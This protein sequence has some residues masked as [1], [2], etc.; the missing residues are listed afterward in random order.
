MIF[1]QARLAE[2][3]GAILAHTHRLPGRT[4]PKGTVLDEAMLAALCAA[5]LDEVVVARPEAGEVAA[6]LV[7][8]RLAALLATPLIARGRAVGGRVELRAEA[9]GLLRVNVTAVERVNAVD[10]AITVA[11]PGDGEMVTS[12]E[13]LAAVTVLPFAV[14]S[15]TVAVVEALARR[16]PLFSLHPFHA[17]RVASV[18]TGP[19]YPGS[20]R[21]I[22]AATVQVE[23]LGGTLLPQL[24]CA[25]D[26]IAIARR[27]HEAVAHG[28]ELVLIAGAFPVTDRRDIAPAAIVA[29]GGAIERLGMPS[30]PGD[31][32]CL[33]HVGPV[34]VV[35]LPS[36][37]AGDGR[38]GL[39]MLLER[40]FTGVPVTSGDIARMG[41]GGLATERDMQTGQPSASDGATR[42]PPPAVAAVVLAAGRSRRMA[43]LNKLL[44]EDAGAPMIARVVDHVLASRARPVIVVLGHQAREVEA[45][46]AGRKVL[47]VEAP[48]YADG[49]SASLKSGIA[50]LPPGA[51][52]AMICL[53]DMPLVST[54][55]MDRLIAAFDPAKGHTIIKPTY[56]GKQGNPMIWGRQH[57][58][59]ILALT[60]DVGARHLAARHA[61]AVAEVEMADDGVL[62]DF[63]TVDTLAGLRSQGQH[64]GGKG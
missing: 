21:T 5:G 25:H 22:A 51:E 54:A 8:D 48:D 6:D 52:A 2:A 43:P 47:F 10:E 38:S 11:T 32:L 31:A 60:G 28:A 1:G 53:G 36:D 4:I 12:R 20:E 3:R 27:I 24:E 40:I 42:A 45:A 23:R 62:R 57:F 58:D 14:P 35:V 46:L 15:S 59:E 39:A 63:D 64:A 30:G 17:L 19:P 56:R 50:A 49:L 18:V 55:M 33:G 29:A 41:V 37:A 44:V 13:R 61:D 7:A 34:P 9:T 16:G 26:T